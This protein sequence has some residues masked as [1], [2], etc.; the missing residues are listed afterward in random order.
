MKQSLASIHPDAKIADNVQISPFVTI[1]GDVEIGSGCWIGP[2]VTI[3]D[4]ARI[5]NDVKIYPGAVIS[6]P[7]QDLKY[8]GEKTLT[9]IG[10][11]TT[12]RECATVNRGTSDRYKTE[13][14]KHCLLMAY[15]HV[16]HDCI[17]GNHVILA[18]L[19]TLAGHITVHDWAILE[20]MVAVQQ[21]I[22]IAEHS[23][24]GGGSLVRKDVPPYVKCAKEPLSF[25]GV[26]VIGLRRR[27]YTEQA[28]R[29]IEDIYRI[30][31]VRGYNMSKAIEM[32]LT[33]V[34]A[35][36]ERDR[37]VGFIKDSNY[38]VIKGMI[39]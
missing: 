19:A 31:Y 33:E 10:E 26:N 36:E 35:S 28:I 21:F 29:Q 13:V 12:I 7:P 38:G 9:L 4:G 32:V 8:K 30:I 34:D 27:G 11:G 3:M 18:N 2:N 16:A 25:A 5:G 17:V 20:G 22:T 24:V 14:G 39:E 6:A 23:F 15:S 1:E 37:I